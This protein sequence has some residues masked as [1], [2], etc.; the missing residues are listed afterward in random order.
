MEEI[1]KIEDITTYPKE[2]KSFFEEEK[3]VLYNTF[4]DGNI[5]LSS[6]VWLYKKIYE[7][8]QD[9]YFYAIHATRLIDKFS[10]ANNGIVVPEYSDLLIDTF[11]KNLKDEF[12]DIELEKIRENLK[13]KKDENNIKD[14]RF[15]KYN[16][17][18][19]ILGQ[20]RDI[21]M[22]NHFYMLKKYGG[23]LL[24]DFFTDI[25]KRKFYFD[26]IAL[27]GKP[28]AVEF[29]IKF[30]DVNIN[31]NT[32]IERILEKYLFDSATENNFIESYTSNNIGNEQI[33][34]ITSIDLE[35]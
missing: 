20:V 18:W 16:K 19:F 34:N 17:I 28:Y 29:M 33:I 13:I 5:I 26:K 1:I 8:I 10:I 15:K 35:E 6:D 24:E 23:E 31:Q 27:K 4:E 9:K 3:E 7:I 12:D 2:L 25:E 14:F 21:S 22:E 32:I 30:K 11:L